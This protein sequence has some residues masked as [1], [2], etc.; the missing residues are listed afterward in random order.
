M[1]ITFCILF[2]V[3]YAILS[4]VFLLFFCKVYFICQLIFLIYCQACCFFILFFH[5]KRALWECNIVFLG[6]SL[7]LGLIEAIW[8]K[9]IKQHW[10]LLICKRL[11]TNS[12]HL[13]KI[14]F[15]ILFIYLIFWIWPISYVA[16]IYWSSK[17]QF[18]VVRK[19]VF[20]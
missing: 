19:T 20:H 9:E 17:T 12:I 2:F 5:V 6:M 8:R 3:W 14:L 13:T 4:T 15:L 18:L 10:I 11:R 7:H 16:H 1:P